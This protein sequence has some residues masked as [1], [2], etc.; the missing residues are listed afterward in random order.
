MCQSNWDILKKDLEWRLEAG[1][2]KILMLTDNKIAEVVELTQ[3]KK[4]NCCK[5]SRR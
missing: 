1:P 3:W 5:K 4:G 2:Q